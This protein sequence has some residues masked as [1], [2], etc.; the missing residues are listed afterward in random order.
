MMFSLILSVS[1][2]ETVFKST[3]LEYQEAL[4][5]S[6]YKSTLKYKPK[7]NTKQKQ[8]QKYYTVQTTI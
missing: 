8:T 2:N 6:D 3:K 4:R 1:S 5:K 7:T